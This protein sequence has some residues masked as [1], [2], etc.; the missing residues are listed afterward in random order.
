MGTTDNKSKCTSHDEKIHKLVN[1]HNHCS[2]SVA[3]NHFATGVSVPGSGEVPALPIFI[4]HKDIIAG[5]KLVIQ[6]IRPNWNLEFVE[7]K[8]SFCFFFFKVYRINVINNP[9]NLN[10]VH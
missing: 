9:Q 3:T 8:V 1:G 6:A 5:A 10:G 2:S 7:F 4:D